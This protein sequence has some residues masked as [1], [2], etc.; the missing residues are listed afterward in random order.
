MFALILL[1]LKVVLL[2]ICVVICVAFIYILHVKFYP[3]YQANIISCGNVMLES[4][5][6]TALFVAL[7]SPK[8]FR[9]AEFNTA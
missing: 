1:A 4:Y 9:L 5:Q 8:R 2:N 7:R 3:M 6:L